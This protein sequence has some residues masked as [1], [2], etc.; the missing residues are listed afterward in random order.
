[1]KWNIKTID[2]DK[3]TVVVNIEMLGRLTPV[4]VDADK[5][6]LMS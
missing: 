1:M 5:I 4:A 6:E 3:W 2:H